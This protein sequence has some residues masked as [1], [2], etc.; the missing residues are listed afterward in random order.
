MRPFQSLLLLFLCVSAACSDSVSPPEGPRR[1]EPQT[2]SAPTKSASG[3]I[4]VT[5]P[6]RGQQVVSPIEIS[7]QAMVFENRVSFRLR[8]GAN[9]MLGEGVAVA[10]SP[11][12]GQSGPFVGTLAFAP[13]PE[14]TT[15]FLEVFSVRP[16]DGAPD[17]VVTIPLELK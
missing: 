12:V 4:E 2:S 7:G 16:Q 11:D 10:T 17:H 9:E 15:A 3:R 8:K 5:R 14:G 1:Q 13:Q 6:L